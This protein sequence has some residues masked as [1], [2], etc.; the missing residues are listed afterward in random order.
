MKPFSKILFQELN[1]I[2]KN[3]THWIEP[4]FST[5]LT[6]FNPSFQHSLKEFYHCSFKEKIK[7]LNS[8]QKCLKELNPFCWTQ[9]QELNLFFIVTRRIEIFEWF[10]E[11]NFFKCDSVTRRIKPL[12]WLMK[13]KFEYDQRIEPFNVIQ[14]FFFKWPKEIDFFVQCDS[15]NW[16]FENDSNNWT[17]FLRVIQRV[18]SQK[19]ILSTEPFLK[20]W[21]LILNWLTDFFSK[22]IWTLLIFWNDSH[23]WLNFC[24]IRFTEFN[25]F[26][27][28]PERIEPFFL[29]HMI[30]RIDHFF[31]KTSHKNQSFTNM[32]H[33]MKPFVLQMTQRIE[34]LS[35]LNMTQRINWSS[36]EHYSQSSF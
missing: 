26:F 8:F 17:F 20:M 19:M 27:N 32:T 16:F 30:L 9:L 1:L 25:F 3:M 18:F 12:K 23:H 10:E 34:L 24:W 22:K 29:S 28:T 31:D 15:K 6:E 21:F 13:E 33:K 7:E 5:W 11:L 14:N 35:F 2:L 36:F 4:F